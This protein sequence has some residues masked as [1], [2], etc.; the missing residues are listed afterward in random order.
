MPTAG[1][2]RVLWHGTTRRR[3]EA[4][5]RGG[6][7]PNFL[8]PGTMVKAGGF[9]TAPTH[10]PYPLGDPRDYASKK[11]ALFADEGG[12]AILEVE[13]PEEI[14]ALAINEVVEI[15]FQ[16]NLGLEELCQAWPELPK[17]VLSL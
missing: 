5:L 3:A 15:R 7:D 2:S 6:P 12:P 13:I 14:V 8:E 4:I 9:S 16:P 1:Q 10:G 11:A 17:R